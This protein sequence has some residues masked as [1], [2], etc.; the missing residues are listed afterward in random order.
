MTDPLNEAAALTR[1]LHL[2]SSALPLGSFAYSQGLEWAVEAGWVRDAP[3]LEAW[4]GDLLEN[5]WGRLELPLL[6]RFWRARAQ[7]D[8]AAFSRWG[9]WLRASRETSELR[10]D[11]AQRGRAMASLLVA[12]DLPDAPSWQPELSVG[13]VAGFAFAAEAWAITPAQALLGY[14]WSAVEAQ[15]MAGVKLI[16]LGQSDGQRCLLRLGETLPSRVAQTLAL[17][18]SALGASLPA[19]AI[20]SACHETQYTRLFRS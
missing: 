14:A 13:P 1:L 4:V 8:R 6:E 3:S 20:A 18:D 19:Q 2:S 11:E 5:A 15:V 12:L 7:R 9:A 17:P 16:P 10:A